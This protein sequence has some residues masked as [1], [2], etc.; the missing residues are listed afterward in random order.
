MGVLR[1]CM[2]KLVFGVT[3]KCHIERARTLVGDSVWRALATNKQTG[4]GAG[5]P[6]GER[7]RDHGAQAKRREITAAIW[8]HGA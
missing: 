4:H 7:A 2:N 6:A 1:S 3:S 8:G 5:H